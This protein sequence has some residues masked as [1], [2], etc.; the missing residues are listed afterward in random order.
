MGCGR[1]KSL[2]ERMTENGVDVVINHVRTADAAPREIKLD[3]EFAI[4]FAS[5]EAARIGLAEAAVVAVDSE[6]NIYMG[7]QGESDNFIYKFDQNGK[8]IA[9]FGRKGQGPG[10]IQFLVGGINVV[11]SSS[12]IGLHRAGGLLSSAHHKRCSFVHAFA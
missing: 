3:R 6:G 9:S 4:D 10:E 1:Q 7:N 5:D 8:F 2:V 11:T 12:S